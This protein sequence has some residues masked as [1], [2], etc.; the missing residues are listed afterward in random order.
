MPPF[1]RNSNGK[2]VLWCP[3]VEVPIE[4]ATEAKTSTAVETKIDVPKTADTPTV[5]KTVQTPVDATA[6]TAIKP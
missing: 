5:A 4:K 1:K 2:C 6:K 3:K